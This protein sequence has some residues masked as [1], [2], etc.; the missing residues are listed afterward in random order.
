M[1][2]I[3]TAVVTLGSCWAGCEA[4]WRLLIAA[5]NRAIRAERAACCTGKVPF[6]YRHSEINA[7]VCYREQIA[8]V[9]TRKI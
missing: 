2:D 8:A 5:G 1:S 4:A 3:L 9:A 7:A 6:A